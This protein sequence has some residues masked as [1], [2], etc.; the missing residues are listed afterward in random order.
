MNE[1]LKKII[2]E[3]KAKI[4]A[5]NQEELVQYVENKLEADL[6]PHLLTKDN[7]VK[8]LDTDEGYRDAFLPKYNKQF[9]KYK[10]EKLPGLIDAEVQK[11]VA[12]LNPPKTDAE[13][14]VA[15]LEQKYAEMERNN[16]LAGI[17]TKVVKLAT[18]KG[19]P[20][21][22]AEQL[23]KDDEDGTMATLDLFSNEFT[24]AVNAAVESR[25]KGINPE[26]GASGNNPPESPDDKLSDTEYFAKYSAK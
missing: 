7:I 16:R 3:M 2:A 5:G 14:R 13:K 20:I 19:L 15:E 6:S 21:S 23:V 4:E 9:E 18:E 11:K 25:M 24:T 17:R 26:P 10:A 1:W 22:I 12:E 8:Y